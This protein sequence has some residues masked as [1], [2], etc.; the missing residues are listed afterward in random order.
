MQGDNS[1]VGCGERSLEGPVGVDAEAGGGEVHQV[2][3]QAQVRAPR[4]AVR[5]VR[6]LVEP[7][8]LRDH[9]RHMHCSSQRC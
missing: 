2:V 4:V 1:S 3:G 7:R 9:L 5:A 8:H 6:G